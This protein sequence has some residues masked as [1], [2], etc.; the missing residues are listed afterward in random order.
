VFFIDARLSSCSNY[1]IANKATL[2]R[3]LIIIR[4][5]YVFIFSSFIFQILTKKQEKSRKQMAGGVK[6]AEF[7]G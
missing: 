7:Q 6:E 3:V 1:A 4:E 2:R 5:H